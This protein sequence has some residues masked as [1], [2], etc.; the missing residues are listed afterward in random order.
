MCS[1]LQAIRVV[2]DVGRFLAIA[3]GAVTTGLLWG[4]LLSSPAVA[5]ATGP[6]GKDNGFD[7]FNLQFPGSATRVMFY[8]LVGIVIIFAGTLIGMVFYRDRTDDGSGFTPE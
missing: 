5:E 6:P 4:L 3:T 1:H 7:I 2:R 8:V